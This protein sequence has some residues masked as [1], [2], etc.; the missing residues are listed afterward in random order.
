MM[1]RCST[2]ILSRRRRAGFS[3][4][5]VVIAVIV[6]G[7]AVPPVLNMLD[8]AS[9]GRA[10]AINTT[11][12]TL[13]ATSVLEMVMGDMSSSAEELGFEAL[14]DPDAYLDSP[15]TGLRDRLEPLLEP[16]TDAGFTWDLD[17]GVLV[18]ADGTVSADEDENIFRQIRVRIHYPS[19]SNGSYELPVSVMVS[20][21]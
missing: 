1:L 5:E 11:R 21:I 16:Y 3:L 10:D 18:S 13:M 6:L 20:A 12:A 7:I 19:A 14:S 8:L 4:I 17:I 2:R 15:T 9:G